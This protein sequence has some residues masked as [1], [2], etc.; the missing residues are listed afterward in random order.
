[1]LFFI[2]GNIL[3]LFTYSLYFSCLN[4][5][6]KLHTVEIFLGWFLLEHV[7][8]EYDTTAGKLFL[9]YEDFRTLIKNILF[10]IRNLVFVAQI[11]TP[12]EFILINIILFFLII[13]HKQKLEFDV[14]KILIISI[15][16]FI[17]N[18]FLFIDLNNIFTGLCYVFVFYL[19]FISSILYFNVMYYF[20]FLRVLHRTKNNFNF[21]LFTMKFLFYILITFFII[22]LVIA[23]LSVYSNL[24][25]NFIQ[26]FVLSNIILYLYF[27]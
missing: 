5:I 3:S 17:F 22:F 8:E 18:S 20:V 4:N 15:Y 14:V 2:V 11:L 7:F 23:C 12:A 19:L 21:K 27:F 24:S 25:E 1:M 9:N 16:G 13:K 26:E 10:L 6:E